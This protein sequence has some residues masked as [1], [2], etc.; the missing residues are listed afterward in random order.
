M[1][2][3][4]PEHDFVSSSFPPNPS[5]LFRSH[6]AQESKGLW[7]EIPTT[8]SPVTLSLS[9]LK[10]SNPFLRSP[11]TASPLPPL[12]L[13]SLSIFFPFNHHLLSK[14]TTS[15]LLFCLS[16][17][18]FTIAV[19]ACVPRLF[20]HISVISQ[21]ESCHCENMI[22]SHQTVDY[23][24]LHSHHAPSPPYGSCTCGLAYRAS[25]TPIRHGPAFKI[26]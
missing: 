23:T 8:S 7:F 12:S 9:S 16:S 10:K 21:K 11:F 25:K 22:C 4:Q 2:K 20:T 24:L 26:S 13:L 15:P 3:M 19:V 18:C 14:L 6:D 1:Q 5:N 17:C